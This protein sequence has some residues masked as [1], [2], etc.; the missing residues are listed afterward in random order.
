MSKSEHFMIECI[1]KFDK[2]AH[3]KGFKENEMN[4]ETKITKKDDTTKG[5]LKSPLI[6]IVCFDFSTLLRIFS[7]SFNIISKTCF[8]VFG[9]LYAA[10]L[11][12]CISGRCI[13]I[14]SYL[15]WLFFYISL[16]STSFSYTYMAAPPFVPS[17]LADLNIL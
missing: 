3:F 8:L 1:N 17:F 11:I 14:I 2:N 9:S 13:A 16:A 5:K 4:K 7:S 15:L 6:I 10:I 12:V